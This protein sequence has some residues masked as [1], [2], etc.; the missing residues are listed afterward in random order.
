MFQDALAL[1]L[2][3]ATLAPTESAV[4][5]FRAVAH[6]GL[7]HENA[8]DALSAALDNRTA[9]AAE[10]IYA[11]T[12][13]LKLLAESPA[14][15]CDARAAFERVHSIEILIDQP[16]SSELPAMLEQRTQWLNQ[17]LGH[18]NVEIRVQAITYLT[19]RFDENRLASLD[20]FISHLIELAQ[21][22]REPRPCGGTGRQRVLRRARAQRPDR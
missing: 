12:P 16:D 5:Y 20:H 9:E 11:V 7:A 22:D 1:P 8:L 13:L 15:P 19:W 21:S 2:N 17:A 14:P 10:G 4:R 18:R 6:V 3:R